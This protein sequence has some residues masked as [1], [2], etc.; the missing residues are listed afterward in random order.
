VLTVVDKQEPSPEEV[1]ANFQKT[2]DGLLDQK[3]GEI[4]GI[5]ADTLTQKYTK[6][7]AIKYNAKAQQ[8]APSPF[9]K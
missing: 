8:A 6:A 1:V 3:K 4:F 2:K 7:G 9:G 5:Y